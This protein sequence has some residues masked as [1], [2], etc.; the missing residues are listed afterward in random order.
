MQRDFRAARE[1]IMWQTAN[2]SGGVGTRA[3]TQQTR[4]NTQMF[5]GRFGE[6]VHRDKGV[7]DGQ[8]LRLNLAAC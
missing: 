7:G 6:M 8:M 3:R 2:T 5:S 4:T 1:E